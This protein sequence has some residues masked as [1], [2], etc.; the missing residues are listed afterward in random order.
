M[1]IWADRYE[2]R[3]TLG[4]GGS[5]TVHLVWDRKLGRELA[6][7]LLKH[8][9]E[10]LAVREAHALTKLESPH[11]L[12]VFN[13]GV[14]TDVPFLATDIAPLGS[15]ED[16]IT[17]DAGVPPTLAVRWV[18]QALVGLDYCHRLNV[19]HRDVTP[20]NIFLASPDHSMLGDF[21]A[22]IDLDDAGTAPAAG[23]QR[24]RAPE[25]FGGRL[26][27]SSDVFSMSASLWRLLTSEW[28]FSAPT[29]DELARRMR[30][31]DRPRLRDI[32]PHVHRSIARVVERGLDPDPGLRPASA[33]DMARLLAETETHRRNWVRLASTDGQVEFCATGAGTP[34]MTVVAAEGRRRNVETRHV[35]TGRRVH[36]G[37]FETTESKL[38][39]SLRRLFDHDLA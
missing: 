36:K 24:C 9:G 14:H 20:S 13:A 30:A 4:S 18:R 33:A 27:T 6:L 39:Q 28:P 7:K 17:A 38:A 25:G 16:Q 15:A 11:I 21:G 10:I 19:L 26:S 8:G 22:A 34:L 12:R 37:C 29:E 31:A 35:A 2:I 3:S 1:T 5:G 32:V 23:N